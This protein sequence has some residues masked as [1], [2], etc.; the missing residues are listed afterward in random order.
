VI[1]L[2]GDIH[3]SG[4]RHREF[5]NP[6]LDDLPPAQRP[7]VNQSEAEVAGEYLAI[8][9]DAGLKVTFFVTGL[10]LRRDRDAMTALVRGPGLEIG[11]HTYRAFEPLRLHDWFRRLA[12]SYYGPAWFQRWDVKRTLAIIRRRLGTPALA[13]RTHAYA[14]DRTTWRVLDALGVRILSDRVDLDTV[15]P[16]PLIGR[17]VSLPIN[18]LPDHEHLYHAERTPTAFGGAARAAYTGPEWLAVVQ[19]QIDTIELRGGVATL[20]VHPICM[21]TLDRFQTFRA[22]CRFLAGRA[23]VLCRDLAGRPAVYAPATRA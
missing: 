4:F 17:L 23:S 3:H 7:Y 6:G 10:A 8:A 12:G 13:W 5:P 1:C 20:L 19:R 16:Q 9:R 21:Y 2:T 22:L 14:S 11:G 15:G 18:V